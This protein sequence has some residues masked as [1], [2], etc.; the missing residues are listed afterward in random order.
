MRKWFWIALTICLKLAISQVASSLEW[1][2]LWEH[3]I[4]ENLRRF[5]S[6]ILWKILVR[7]RW[8]RPRILLIL[9]WPRMVL[10]ILTS[11]SALN[12]TLLFNP[13]CQK[14]EIWGLLPER[15]CTFS[16]TAVDVRLRII[17]KRSLPSYLLK[18]AWHLYKSHCCKITNFTNIF[19]NIQWQNVEARI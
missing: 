5:L 18:R 16:L 9:L 14:L 15:G 8:W 13:R 17:A 19:C 11:C 2:R 3:R 4:S 7:L 10:S 6:C 1:T 12:H